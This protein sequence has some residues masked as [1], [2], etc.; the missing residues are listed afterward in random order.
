MFIHTNNLLTITSYKGLDP[1]TQQL[2]GT[3]PPARTVVAGL[4]FNF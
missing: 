1:E 3:M 2:F 4:T